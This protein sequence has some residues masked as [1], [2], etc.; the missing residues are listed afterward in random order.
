MDENSEFTNI[1][2]RVYGERV[3]MPFW[4]LRQIGE[5]KTLDK[6]FFVR[7]F[8]FMVKHWLIIAGFR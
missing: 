4:V 5:Y 7:F 6:P 1:L 2:Q 3:K 8:V